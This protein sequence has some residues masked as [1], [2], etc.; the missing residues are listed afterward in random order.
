MD[1]SS[2]K[3][4]PLNRKVIDVY[5]RSKDLPADYEHNPWI[6]EMLDK[7]KEAFFFHLAHGFPKFYNALMKA[8]DLVV[9]KIQTDD[10]SLAGQKNG[11]VMHCYELV[12]AYGDRMLLFGLPGKKANM[13]PA[14]RMPLLEEVASQKRLPRY[15]LDLYLT[16]NGIRD[17]H[18]WQPILNQ[19]GCY[20]EIERM[21]ATYGWPEARIVNYL[22][23]R[24]G[25]PMAILS[26][27]N[28]CLVLIN[29]EREE[30]ALYC[31]DISDFYSVDKI[32]NTQA[33]FDSYLTAFLTGE[34]KTDE[35]DN[36]HQFKILKSSL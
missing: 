3:V 1:Y 7:G 28:K 35:N 4:K 13:S 19:C 23:N 16:F 36:S 18:T 30:D 11:G 10:W 27:V 34:I 6:G 12:I 20:I 22:K 21:I 5:R 26:E 33:V 31:A 15:L 25:N 32:G 29:K 17:F 2:F 24:K 14:V 8:N 9:V